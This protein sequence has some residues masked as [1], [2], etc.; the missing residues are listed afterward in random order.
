[1]TALTAGTVKEDGTITPWLPNNRSTLYLDPGDDLDARA[2]K[3]SEWR[4]TLDQHDPQWSQSALNSEASH[5]TA[6]PLP[7]GQFSTPQSQFRYH[8]LE[9][10][11]LSQIISLP[12]ADGHEHND[13]EPGSQV[14]H[15]DFPNG[16]PSMVICSGCATLALSIASVFV[17]E[18]YGPGVTANIDIGGE[19]KPWSE[20]YPDVYAALS[21][22]AL[23]AGTLQD[24]GTVTPFLPNGCSTLHLKPDDGK[25]ERKEKISRWYHDHKNKDPVWTWSA[26]GPR[27]FVMCASSSNSEAEPVSSQSQPP[28]APQPSDQEQSSSPS[29]VTSPLQAEPD[30]VLVDPKPTGSS[31]PS[32][33]STP[34]PP[35]SQP[36]LL[37]AT[38]SSLQKDSF[39]FDPKFRQNMKERFGSF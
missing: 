26:F 20:V 16:Q 18:G 23:T 22:T 27:L 34:H 17:E 13:P 33:A 6:V 28:S 30:W 24:D 12:R 9:D 31:T 36:T 32:P 14:C 39:D 25:K 3:I 15:V 19:K 8:I 21:M 4:S 37:S 11:S 1:M 35:S 2:D 10:L 5:T 7:E 38:A 29:G